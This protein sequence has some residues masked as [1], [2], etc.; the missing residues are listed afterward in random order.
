MAAHASLVVHGAPPASGR[1]HAP[2]D[3]MFTPA[4]LARQSYAYVFPSH[5]QTRSPGGVQD[6]VSRVPGRVAQEPCASAAQLDFRQ[7][8]RE[9]LQSSLPRHP[10]ASDAASAIASVGPSAA[11][12]SDRPS[13]PLS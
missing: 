13:G 2:T 1:G 11:L 7:N 3:A 4:A 12:P 6:P 5:P 10:A 8:S 9:G